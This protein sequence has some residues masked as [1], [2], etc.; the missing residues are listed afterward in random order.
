META[1]R[2]K[3]KALVLE[4]GI[5]MPYS[6]TVG[7]VGSRFFI[8]MRDNRRLLANRC[9]KCS[10]VWVPPRKRCPVCFVLIA[11]KDWLEVGPSGT[12]RHVSVVRYG[13]PA[14]PLPTPF[15]YGIIDLDGASHGI[16]HIVHCSDLARLR[17]GTRVKPLWREERQGNILD[18]VYFTPEE[19]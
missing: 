10:Y 19:S 13:N 2:Q 11:D 12:L 14:Q 1:W 17:P 18:I 15:A 7:R 8:A 5:H 16:T 4:G 9:P 6:W 3:T